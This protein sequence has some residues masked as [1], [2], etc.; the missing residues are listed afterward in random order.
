VLNNDFEGVTVRFFSPR[1]CGIH[2][3]V[4]LSIDLVL[5][6]TVSLNIPN[7][8]DEHNSATTFTEVLSCAV[9]VVGDILLLKLP[10]VQ[11]SIRY[12]LPLSLVEVN[13]AN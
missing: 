7:L 10:G 1:D 6:V 9:G 4:L 8:I 2:G 3:C 11:G 5:D 13:Q 12:I